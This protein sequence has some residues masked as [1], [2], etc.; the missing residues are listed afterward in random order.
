MK[1]LLASMGLLA[2]WWTTMP[3]AVAGTARVVTVTYYLT[4]AQGTVIAT[5]DAQG[6]ILSRRFHRPYGAVA[7]GTPQAGPGYTGHVNDP[8]TGL[9]YMQ[10]RYYDPDSGRFPSPDPI[11]PTP[12]NIYSFNRYAYA[13]NNP[14][15]YI[16][17]DG[18]QAFPGDHPIRRARQ[19]AECDVQCKQ[20]RQQQREN[21]WVR[22]LGGSVVV[23]QQPDAKS[24]TVNVAGLLSDLGENSRVSAGK[25]KGINGKWYSLGWGGNGATGARA[26]AFRV[27]KRFG[28]LGKGFFL[29]SAGMDT[30]AFVNALSSGNRGAMAGSAS[31]ITWSALGTF[32]G[33]VGLVGS[34]TYTITMQLEKI[35]IVYQYTVIPVSNIY[36]GLSPSNACF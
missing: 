14:V 16:D 17:S 6:N 22:A 2:L 25:W 20:E 3:A 24:N 7:Q 12:G 28:L 19:Q 10:Q 30:K 34:L 26:R 23:F 1:R 35:P 8:D 32:G 36:C 15:R 18:R 5:Q 9:V 33:G 11:G 21:A 27:A 31:A 13:N 4:D 29:L